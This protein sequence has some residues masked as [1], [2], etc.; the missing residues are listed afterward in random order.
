[1]CAVGGAGPVTLWGN[2]KHSTKAP[3]AATKIVAERIKVA[4][5]EAGMSQEVLGEASGVTFQQI[6]KYESGRNR[7]SADRLQRIADALEKPISYFFYDGPLSKT[8]ADDELLTRIV[9]WLEAG[10]APR[11]ILA[12]LPSL[13]G[14]DVE[15]AAAMLERL[16]RGDQNVR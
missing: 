5:T 6:Q 4:R 11:R 15:L 10:A 8:L 1:M 14:A 7:V 12:A 2:M 16:V 9:R 3:G 13:K